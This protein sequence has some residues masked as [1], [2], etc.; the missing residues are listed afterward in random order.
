M[1]AISSQDVFNYLARFHD[2]WSQMED[3][4]NK[5]VGQRAISDYKRMTNHI[6]ITMD[7][8]RGALRVPMAPDRT[9]ATPPEAALAPSDL[10]LAPE[11]SETAPALPKKRGRPR[12]TPPPAAPEPVHD[13]IKLTIHGVE[14]NYRAHVR[15]LISRVICKFDMAEGDLLTDGWIKEISEAA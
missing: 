13:P 6:E 11:T 8:H 3:A 2:N 10:E 12:K 5:F 14:V 4:L 15:G 1:P 9:P 7:G